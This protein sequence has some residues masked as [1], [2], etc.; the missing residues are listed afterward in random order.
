MADALSYMNTPVREDMQNIEVIDKV[1]RRFFESEIVPAHKPVVFKGLVTDWP[2]VKCA[3]R[4][5]QAV[6]E[7]LGERDTPGGVWT[8]ETD[9]A[10]DRRFFYSDDLKGFNFQRKVSS[11]R[12]FTQRLL[13]YAGKASAPALSIQSAFVDEYFYGLR[14][15][16]P[17]PLFSGSVRPR[18]WIGNSSVVATHYDD[19]ENIAC[20]GAGTRRFTLFPPD[21]I[22]NLYVGPLDKTPAGAPVSMASLTPPELEKFP[23][24]ATALENA[25]VAE[26][27]AGDAIYIPTL[28]WHHVEALADINVLVNFWNGGSLTGASGPMPLDSLLLALLTLKSKPRQVKAAWKAFFDYYV[29]EMEGEPGSHLPD[30][31]KG[32]LGE[33]DEA[34]AMHLKKWLIQ[35][36]SQDTDS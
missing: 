15:T 19:A 29:F 2:L 5:P 25:L 21:Q 4:S 20:V 13:D 32:I 17:M 7:Y 28:W 27:E 34:G 3:R 23:K 18:I 11:F 8:L 12:K 14:E 6:M 31:L 35:Q 22:K 30:D 16:H 1:D 9:S 10:A 36:L 26:L 24:L 33:I